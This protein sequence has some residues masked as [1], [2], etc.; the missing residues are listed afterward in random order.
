LPEFNCVW[1]HIY[2]GKMKK[3]IKKKPVKKV[4]KKKPVKKATKKKKA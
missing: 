1:L 4:S 2:G 3:Q